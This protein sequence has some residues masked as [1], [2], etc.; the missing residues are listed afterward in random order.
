M[1]LYIILSIKLTFE[2]VLTI[3]HIVSYNICAP[4]FA[5][6]KSLPQ[7]DLQL[8]KNHIIQNTLNI[9]VQKEA[10]PPPPKKNHS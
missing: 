9:Q 10:Q 3:P 7:D 6:Q 5:E 8:I 1:S 2:F 4:P